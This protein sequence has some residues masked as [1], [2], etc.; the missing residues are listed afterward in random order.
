MFKNFVTM[1][2]TALNLWFPCSSFNNL[3]IVLKCFVTVCT[4]S[5][6]N[7]PPSSGCNILEIIAADRIHISSFPTVFAFLFFRQ[8]M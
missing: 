8:A 5:P 4:H 7:S 3:F 6:K 1:F 2:Y